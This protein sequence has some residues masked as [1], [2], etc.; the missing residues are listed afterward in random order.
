[1]KKGKWTGCFCK[2]E[3]QCFKILK[4]IL[5]ALGILQALCVLERFLYD[6]T[7]QTDQSGD[8]RN[9]PIPGI[10]Y[11][12]GLRIPGAGFLQNCGYHLEGVQF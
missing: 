7:D 11:V 10:S 4:P 12:P 9:S 5:A 8:I 3:R 2:M 1:M 6:M